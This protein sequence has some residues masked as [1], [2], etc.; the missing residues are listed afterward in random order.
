MPNRLAHFY[1]LAL[2]P[3]AALAFWPSY[4]SQLSTASGEFHWHGATATL[5]LILLVAQSLTIH[6]GQRPIHRAVGLASLA[7]FPL[8][9]MGGVGIFFGMAERYVAGEPFQA[10]YAPRLAWLDFAGVG[11]FAYCDY[12]AL[13]NRRKVHP[14]S[15]YM[16]ATAIFLLPP[17]FGRLT[18]IPLGVTGPEDFL[19]LSI[20]FQAANALTAAIAFGLAWWSGKHGR[21]FV[22]AGALT[23]A[24]AVLYETIGG[25]PAWQAL[26][27]HVADF[28]K[29]PFM[30]AAGVAGIAIAY[31]G[32]VAGRRPIT[33][34]AVPA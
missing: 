28:P 23:V 26:Y 7:L 32:W 19:R 10:M 11:G 29:A 9:L 4:L 24:G 33:P 18:G 14:H 17:I 16:L 12:E 22:I 34:G 31:A 27:A 25:M 20:G 5:W 30:L 6:R 21:P 8:F 2:F 3:L 15:R 13:R 1:V